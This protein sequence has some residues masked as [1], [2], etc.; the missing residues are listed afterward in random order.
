MSRMGFEDLEAAREV[1]RRRSRSVG[2][3]Q[4]FADRTDHVV[5]EH[6][7]LDASTGIATVSL[8]RRYAQRFLGYFKIGGSNV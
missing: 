8:A 7:S 4:K 5:E 1:L 3:F 6:A 2:Q